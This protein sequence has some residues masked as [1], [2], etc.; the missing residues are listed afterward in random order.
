MPRIDPKLLAGGEQTAA[1]MD[2]IAFSEGTARSPVTRDDGYD[3]IVNS[4]DYAGRIVHNR[5]DDYSKHPFASGRK[6]LMINKSGLFST[7]SG[8]YQALLRWWT[9]YVSLLN[10]PDFSPISQDRYCERLLKERNVITALAAGDVYTAIERCSNI[11]ASLPGKGNTY[12]QGTRK[13]DDLRLAF[14]TAG[15]TIA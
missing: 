15:G 6:A 10:L 1:F 9:P 2:M 12:G 8:R 7:A 5:F 13:L 14:T 3:I 4:I 11:W